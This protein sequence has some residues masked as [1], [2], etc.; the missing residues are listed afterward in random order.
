MYLPPP[1]ETK[2]VSE[3]APLSKAEI[4]ILQKIR[5]KK[6]LFIIS[7]YFPLVGVL[8]WAWPEGMV[9]ARRFGEDEVARY[10]A[11]IPYAELFFFLLLSIYFLNYYYKSVR[12]YLRDIKKG[13]K[14]LIYFTPVT[15]KTPFFAEYFLTTDLK[16][17]KRIRISK[18]MYDQMNESTSGCISIAPC[19]QFVFSITVNDT[20]ILF[21]D[22][23]E[24]VF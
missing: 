7:S 20:C 9:R 1:T 2:L 13:T 21:N 14:T 6:F 17:R 18:E 22:K 11:V 8:I 5:K 24:A 19:S 10:V 23:N 16:D 15:Y 12:P 3:P 4:L